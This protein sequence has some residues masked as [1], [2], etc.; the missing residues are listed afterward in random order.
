MERAKSILVSCF[1]SLR[2]RAILR[3]AKTGSPDASLINDER[4][5]NVLIE[6]VKSN[7]IEVRVAA[8]AWESESR[9]QCELPVRS[10]DLLKNDPDQVVRRKALRSMAEK[11]SED[12]IE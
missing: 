7:F 3:I 2:R 8:A 1:G 4:S 5:L 11:S 12:R 10:L 9:Q 6:A